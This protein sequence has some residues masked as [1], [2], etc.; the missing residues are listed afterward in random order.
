MDFADLA[1]HVGEEFSLAGTVVTLS[2]ASP[3]G[4]GGSLVFSGPLDQPLEQA[5]HSL[6]HPEL[7]EGDLFVVP[8][9]IGA[10]ERTYEAVFS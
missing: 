9:G 10:A 4:T 3:A 2:S 7:G 6:A 5:T 1:A 8:V